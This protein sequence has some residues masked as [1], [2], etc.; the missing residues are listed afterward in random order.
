MMDSRHRN[1]QGAGRVTAMQGDREQGRK[2]GGRRE[3]MQT[4]SMDGRGGGLQNNRQG[5]EDG[6]GE[7]IIGKKGRKGENGHRRRQEEGR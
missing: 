1:R 6:Q 2:T 3:G 5:A 7:E 4:G